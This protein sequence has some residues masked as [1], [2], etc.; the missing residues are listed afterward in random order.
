MLPVEIGEGKVRIAVSKAKKYTYVTISNDF[1]EVTIR[2]QNKLLD[3][4]R[5]VMNHGERFDHKNDKTVVTLEITLETLY[6]L[7]LPD[8]LTDVRLVR[9]IRPFF[10]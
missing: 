10:S 3:L 7:L 8:L 6:D 9:R 1:T 4:T 2:T 5:Y